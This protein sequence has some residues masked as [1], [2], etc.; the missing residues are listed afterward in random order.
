M[1]STPI[2]MI[3]GLNATPRAF[4]AQLETLYR[5]GSVTLADHRQ[6]N[7][8]RD[9]AAAILWDAPPHFILGGFSMGGYIAFEIMRQ[10]PE[11]VRK[12]ILLS[13][14]ARP[15]TPEA[16]ERRQ[17]GME[18]SRAGKFQ[19]AAAATFPTAVHADNKENSELRAVHLDMAMHT[20]PQAYIRQQEAIIAR[21]DSR[22]DLPGIGVPTLVL[23]GDGDQITPPDAAE[24][25]ARAIPGARLVIVPGAGHLAVL[26]QPDAVNAALED[27]LT[28]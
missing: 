11:R 27:F 13:T 6:G 23:V 25:M 12:L 26:E 3:P 15:D 8:V 4:R 9:I 10:A 17:Q 1:A 18:L 24:E 19:L 16:T 28:G 22:P 21:P 5:H 2:L 20:G 7:T 14:S